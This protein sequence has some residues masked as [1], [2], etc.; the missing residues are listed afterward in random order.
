MRNLA[1]KYLNS[2]EEIKQEKIIAVNREIDINDE[3]FYNKAIE[4]L[5]P[6]KKI[7]TKVDNEKNKELK[8][9]IVNK[10]VNKIINDVIEQNNEKIVI[11]LKTKLFIPMFN[12]LNKIENKRK[13]ILKNEFNLFTQKVNQLKIIS[14]YI[15]CIYNQKNKEIEIINTYKNDDL[16]ENYYK[17]NSTF[18][19]IIYRY[20]KY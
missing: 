7:E 4:K 14:N 12:I 15:N 19:M 18:F 6:S 2:K 8:E 11:N 17:S 16:T 20:L 9:L 1:H 13:I 3:M 5:K 10:N